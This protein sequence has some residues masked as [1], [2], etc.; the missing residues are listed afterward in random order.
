LRPNI[1]SGLSSYV[2]SLKS[3]VQCVM[4]TLWSIHGMYITHRTSIVYIHTEH[5]ISNLQHVK[6]DQN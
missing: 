4:Y 3:D 2:A 6:K 1:Y 5:L